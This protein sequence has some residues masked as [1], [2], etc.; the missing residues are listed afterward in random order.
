MQALLKARWIETVNEKQFG[1]QFYGLIGLDLY[2]KLERRG[3]ILGEYEIFESGNA[4]SLI[5]LEMF[6]GNRIKSYL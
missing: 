1:K 3:I 2:D 4:G 6:N 5:N